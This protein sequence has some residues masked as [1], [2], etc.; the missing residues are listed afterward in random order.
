MISLR[1]HVTSLVAVF[2]ALAVGIVLG[3][4][5]LA[6]TDDE[7]DDQSAASASDASDTPDPSTDAYAEEFAAA[8]APR[9]Y[10]DGLDG[11]ATVVLTMPGA[12]PAQVKSLTDQVSAAGGAIT[13]TFAA[14]ETLVDPGQRTLIDT[15][16]NQLMTQL[17]DPRV[18]PA[19]ATYD[20]MGQLIGAGHGHRPGLL[21]ACR[22]RRRH[23][24]A[25]PG[26]RR[27]AHL[28]GRRPQR[29]AHPRRA[30]ARDRGR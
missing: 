30:A 1:Q 17:A 19:A 3:G 28:T 2:L 23:R 4:G 25:G 7:P 6:D 20:R 21:G 5:L 26:R 8:S 29:A 16:G 22:H 9:L 18:D 11:H 13:G 14:T 12:D 15:L 27:G 24:P 10:A